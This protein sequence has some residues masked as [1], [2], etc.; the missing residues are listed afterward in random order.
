MIWNIAIVHLLGLMTPGP[1]FFCVIKT[2]ASLGKKSAVYTVVGIVLGVAFWSMLALFGLA[3][4]LLQTPSFYQ[5]ILIA[6]GCY[7]SWMGTS[8]LRTKKI[9]LQTTYTNLPIKNKSALW[10]I[11]QGLLVNLSNAKVIIY[12]ASVLSYYMANIHNKPLIITVLTLIILETFLY[13]YLIALFFSHPQIRKLYTLYNQRIS[14]LSGV[15]FLLF[16][17]TLIHASFTF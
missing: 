14:Q 9:S 3:I 8:M 2:A 17:L 1:D 11:G 10:H 16:G 12:F 6:G 5:Y 15:I 13:F 7:L 4:F